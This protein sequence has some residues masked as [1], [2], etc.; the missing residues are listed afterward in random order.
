MLKYRAEALHKVGVFLG[1]LRGVA[2]R[3]PAAVDAFR[4]ALGT[5]TPVAP[6]KM[7][8]EHLA[9]IG[10]SLP[11][12]RK[13]LEEVGLEIS[14]DSLRRLEHGFAQGLDYPKLEK[15]ADDLEGRIRDELSHLQLWQVTR[16]EMRFS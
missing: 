6:L 9:S 2:V 12:Y 14:L 3:V 11:E 7:T 1:L 13:A 4:E 10:V 16:E 8:A 5:T 15:L